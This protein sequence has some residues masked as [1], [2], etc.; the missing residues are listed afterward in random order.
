MTFTV[1][2][3]CRQSGDI[4]LASATTSIAVGARLGQWAVADGQE[5][6]IASQAVA[7]PGLGFEAAD[8]LSSGTP[9][10]SLEATLAQADSY[11]AYRQIGVIAK[12]GKNFVY[13]GPQASDWKG[14]VAG[15][16]FVAFG[17]LLAGPQVVD[18]M[19]AGFRSDPGQPLAERLLRA[20]E[21][22]RDAGGQADADG[23]HQPELSAFV[24]VFN[25]GADAFTYGN[26]RSPLLDLRV[27]YDPHAVEKLRGLFEDCRPLRETYELRAK[28]PEAYLARA[29]HWEMDLFEG[30]GGDDG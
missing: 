2:G 13:T 7:R 23:R 16:G 26:G 3:T 15:D 20:I 11:L 6:M 19:A 24:R 5:W 30:K 22:G 25:S 17:N 27:D 18:A 21:G 1:L 4:G 14:H 28:D 8:L 10:D 12:D 9:F 29:A